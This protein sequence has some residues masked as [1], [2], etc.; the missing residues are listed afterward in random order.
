MVAEIATLPWT[1]GLG[2]QTGLRCGC[3][4]SSYPCVCLFSVHTAKNPVSKIGRG[5][6]PDGA[7]FLS[8][9]R[10]GAGLCKLRG[11]C[12]YFFVQ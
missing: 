12:D 5:P 9:V 11:S 1:L 7:H 8:S 6:L 4:K 10:C 3:V 2:W